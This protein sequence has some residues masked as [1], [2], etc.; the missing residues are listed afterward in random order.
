MADLDFYGVFDFLLED[1]DT[2][3]YTASEFV[4]IYQSMTT[5]GVVK[6]SGNEMEV[7]VNGLNVSVNT[8]S[9]FINGRY[10]EI[11]EAKTLTVSSTGTAHI[12]RVILKLDVIARTI[13]VEVKAGGA[14]APELTQNDDVYEIS[15][16]QIA[17]PASG[18]S[19]TM[20]DE[21][22]FFYKPT[23]VMDKMNAITG[24]TEYVYA[25]YA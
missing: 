2:Y 13:S 22:T 16:A 7:T 24:G 6:G 17:V 18:V 3:K 19:T 4:K 25:V 20:V 9:A 1:D 12:D 14:A 21:R 10:G 11:S 23:Q 8:G 5:N 15:L